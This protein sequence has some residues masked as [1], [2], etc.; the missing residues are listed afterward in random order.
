MTWQADIA[1]DPDGVHRAAVLMRESASD[2]RRGFLLDDARTAGGAHRGWQAA[3]ASTRCVAAWRDRL[4]RE[5]D[6]VEAAADALRASANAYVN[7][8]GVTA[9]AL[10]DDAQWLRGA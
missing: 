8:D 2:S 9:V 4:H 6:E 3:N 1:I 7:T 5:A 10:S